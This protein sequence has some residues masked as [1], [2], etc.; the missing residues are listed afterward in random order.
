MQI[1]T[2]WIKAHFE[3]FN[4]DYFGGELPLPKFSVSNS[5][6]CLGVMI[7]R[8]KRKFFICTCNEYTIRISNY[9][10]I[11]EREF[12]NVLLHEMIHY[13]IYIK[14]LKDTSSHGTVFRGLMRTLNSYGWNIAVCTQTEGWAVAERNIKKGRK[15]II[16]AVKTGSDRYMLSVV[17][18]MYM[19]SIDRIVK[20]LPDVVF[21]SWHISSDSYFSTFACVRT[22]RGRVVSRDVFEDKVAK[23]RKLDF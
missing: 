12:Q 20:V 2:D 16:L 1:T 18:P 13:Y 17:N 6:T 11:P 15:Y 21:Y 19:S 3:R 22:P 23:M 5:R 7:K 8:R 14:R 9:Y 4:T 10:D